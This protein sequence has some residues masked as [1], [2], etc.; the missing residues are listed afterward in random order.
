MNQVRHLQKQFTYPYRYIK[1][2]RRIIVK[3]PHK[4]CANIKKATLNCA[5]GIVTDVMS[6]TLLSPVK[7]TTPDIMEHYIMGLCLHTIIASLLLRIFQNEN[8]NQ[9]EESN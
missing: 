5:P 6:E 8:D 7:T 3:N 2:S 9:N 1:I 4:L